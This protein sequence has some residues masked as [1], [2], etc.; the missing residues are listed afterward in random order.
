[1]WSY[2]SIQLL[3]ALVNG[4]D[5]VAKVVGTGEGFFVRAILLI[6]SFF[7]YGNPNMAENNL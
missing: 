2:S 3:S 7:C 1:M 4:I 6:A 5:L